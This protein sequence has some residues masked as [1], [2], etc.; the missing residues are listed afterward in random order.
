MWK[1]DGADEDYWCDFGDLGRTC[2]FI[3]GRR[4]DARIDA[5]LACPSD[6]GTEHLAHLVRHRHGS[7]TLHHVAP[8]MPSL[9]FL[10]I[11]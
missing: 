10:L 11:Q 4:N 2:H 5:L 8:G 1:V 3:K 7:H 9:L 6:D